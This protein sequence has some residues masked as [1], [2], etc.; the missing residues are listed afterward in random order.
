MIDVT[1]LDPGLCREHVRRALAEDLGWGDVTTDALVTGAQRARARIVA[2]HGAILAGIAL[3]EEAFRQLDPL[4]TTDRRADD[5]APIAAGEVVLELRGSAGAVL[6]AERTARNFLNRLTGI[7]T[8]T[9]ECV[10]AARGCLVRS[11]RDTTP[12]V[13]ALEHYAVRVGGGAPYRAALDA[14][15]VATATHV[16]FAADLT[17][18]VRQVLGLQAD[19]PTTIEVRTL[20]EI[21]QALDAGA[22]RL[23]FGLGWTGQ[24]PSGLGVVAGRAAVDLIV[25]DARALRELPDEILRLVAC[26]VVPALTAAPPPAA[27]AFVASP[28]APGGD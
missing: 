2:T 10:D 18:A 15:V 27:F 23:I 13:R 28:E 11:S 20:A 14:G 22:H 21:E 16:Q 4:A 8:L 25:P 17:S 7:A 6:T 19:L 1:P 24:L 26:V 12:G 5:G 9:R 3:A